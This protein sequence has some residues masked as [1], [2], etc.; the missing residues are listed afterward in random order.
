MG[1][2]RDLHEAERERLRWEVPA[3]TAVAGL[4]LL[5]AAVVGGAIAFGELNSADITGRLGPFGAWWEERAAEREAQ[6]L[7]AEPLPDDWTSVHCEGLEN[8]G[9][10]DVIEALVVA[11]RDV[12]VWLTH[13]DGALVFWPGDPDSE[14]G[15]QIAHVTDGEPWMLREV[16]ADATRAEVYA[17]HAASSLAAGFHIAGPAVVCLPELQ[18]LV[19]S[20]G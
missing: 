14:L 5:F 13:P 18:R 4:F 15:S 2:R 19:A 8:A 7:L 11:E 17:V 12:G 20:M 3:A 1:L 9:V 10:V 6:R 16:R